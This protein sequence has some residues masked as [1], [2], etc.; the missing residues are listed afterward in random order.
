M[1]NDGVYVG[2]GGGIGTQSRSFPSKATKRNHPVWMRVVSLRW[3][4]LSNISL[5][6]EQILDKVAAF[7]G[8][9]SQTQMGIVVRDNVCKR[10][11][12][13]VVVETTGLVCP[14]PR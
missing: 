9:Q 11:K 6:R 13:P 12:T 1:V 2:V 3:C 14:Q 4:Y 7:L 8:G 5:Y 10:G